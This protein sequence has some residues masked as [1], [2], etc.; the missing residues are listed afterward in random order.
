MCVRVC[1]WD[2]IIAYVRDYASQ[3]KIA[4]L[5]PLSACMC[6]CVAAKGTI[7]FQSEKV[8]MIPGKKS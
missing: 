2:E 4:P 5:G 3:I 7:K 1:E 6:D 8:C